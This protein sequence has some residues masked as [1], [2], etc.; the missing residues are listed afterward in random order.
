MLLKEQS[1]FC[2]AAV[3]GEEGNIALVGSSRRYSA[4]VLIGMAARGLNLPNS[5]GNRLQNHLVNWA[6]VDASLGDAGLVLW[7]LAL[8]KQEQTVQLAQ[9]IVDCG[10]Q[11]LEKPINHT[12]MSLGWLLTGLSWAFMMD[13]GVQG[14]RTL[15]ETVCQKLLQNRN[16]RTG[17]FS[18][19]RGVGSKNPV[20]NRV[21]S[22]LGS[23]ASQVYPT[24]GLSYYALATGQKAPLRLAEQC[25]ETVCKQQGSA[26][27]WWWI[28][29]VNTGR[30]V[31]RYP[32]FSVH[33]DAMGPM[34]L[35]SVMQAGGGFSYYNVALSRSLSWMHH[36]PECPERDL[37]DE[38]LQLVWRAVQRDRPATTGPFGLGRGE[39]F[40]MALAAYTGTYDERNFHGGYVCL[41]CRPYH[42]GWLLLAA[43]MTDRE[44]QA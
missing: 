25:L 12:S 11:A 24:I 8:R 42:L 21:N 17:L 5:W 32:V 31:V 44:I 15:A 30:P 9:S 19:S 36:H 26:G 22:R 7:A 38:R 27:Q 43:A 41:Q 33:Q 13:V 6:M 20:T 40:R 1:V 37:V 23:F 34:A 2:H 35:L 39:R 16:A 14:L 4:M 3:S 29:N 28:Y 18:L 10:T